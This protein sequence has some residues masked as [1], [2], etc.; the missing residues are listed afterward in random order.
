M[1][2]DIARTRAAYP[3]LTEG[4]AHF[5]GAGGTQT[6]QSVIDAVSAAMGT[7]LGNRTPAFAPGHRSLE[8][9]DAARAAV[10]DLLGAAPRG[11]VLG[12]SATALTY[13]LARTLGATW[14]PRRRG[15]GLPTRP[16]RERAALGAG[17]P[18]GRRD[19]ALGGVRPGH[20]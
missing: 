11:V 20:R 1:P 13:T 16:R 19:R 4:F 3:A 15:G 5:D 17:G 12:P 8:L 9:V 10:A 2:F 14:R 6:P 7:A 18:G